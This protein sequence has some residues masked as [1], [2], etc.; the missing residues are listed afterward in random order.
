MTATSRHR[1]L[2]IDDRYVEQNATMA[3]Q[4]VF[5][6]LTELVTNSDDAYSR[7]NIKNGRIEI[8]V[9]RRRKGISSIVKVRDFACGFTH[10]EMV[11]KLGSIGNRHNS[12]LA[13]GANVRGTNSRG[14]KDIH[15]LGTVT[16]ESIDSDGTFSKCCIHSVK[17]FEIFP[18]EK[19][20]ALVR[21]TLGIRKGSG[22]VVTLEVDPSRTKFIPQHDNLKK[23]L[24][25]LVPLRLILA[26]PNREVI[27]YNKKQQ[28]KDVIQYVAP[29]GSVRVKE[30]FVV[31]GYPQS[32]V[33]LIIKRTKKPLG[34]RGKFRKSGIIIQSRKAVH[35]S[36]LFAPDFEHDPV[37]AR[38]FGKLRCEYIDDLW[39]EADD[40][41]Y[42]NGSPKDSRNPSLIYDP[43]RQSGL[44][45]GHPFFQALKREVLKR[46]RPLVENERA[47]EIANLQQVE[48]LE[49][50]KKLNKLEQIATKFLQDEQEDYDDDLDN[51]TTNVTNVRK[52][53]TDYKLSPPYC[54]MV[55][56]QSQNF[57][58]TVNQ[59][60]YP[61]LSKGSA[62]QIQCES[63]H[64]AAN[65]LSCLLESHPADEGI[66]RATWSV[67]AQHPVSTTGVSI[68]VGA[69][70]EQ[71]LIEVVA[72]KQD[73][74][75]R[76]SP[77]LRQ[78]HLFK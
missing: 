57:S 15:A 72:T 8:E 44:V 4:D 14:A 19:A 60:N 51:L 77:R 30:T 65:R 47:R 68:S 54:K 66:L 2:L 5:D 73:L 18:P 41:I 56:G 70:T 17:D 76:R 9:D 37:A 43:R 61:E 16:F 64:V 6:A 28:R 34:G 45:R 71:A 11:K 67:T 78:D 24:T 25:D 49:T 10:D 69:I 50:R 74:Y 1:P 55:V 48:N 33:K 20:N 23:K 21:Q 29:D 40:S 38:F 59:D 12:G 13:E 46:L 75:L 3:I 27:L 31:P 32:S 63:T 35:E 42:K 22:T 52:R 39:N 36:T 58:L 26:D 62:V 53:V 7:S